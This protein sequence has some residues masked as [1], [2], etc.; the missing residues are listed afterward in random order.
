MCEKDGSER[1][2]RMGW[3]QTR[4]MVRVGRLLSR[5][6]R[7]ERPYGSQHMCV[8]TNQMPSDRSCFDLMLLPEGL[9]AGVV[10]SDLAAPIGSRSAAPTSSRC[11][12]TVVNSKTPNPEEKETRSLNR[13]AGD[14]TISQWLVTN[15]ER[16]SS[17]AARSRP[18]NEGF[19]AVR[20]SAQ[21]A[22]SGQSTPLIVRIPLKS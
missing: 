10:I 4:C 17:C 15:A 16:T 21:N 7:G 12:T 8:N 13:K 22:A 18:L 20:T 14:E 19:I 6:E 3:G 9:L 1:A 5:A 11:F 2:G